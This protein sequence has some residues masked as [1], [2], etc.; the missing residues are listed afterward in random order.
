MPFT[1][2]VGTHDKGEL[3]QQRQVTA[4][5]SGKGGLQ[6]QASRWGFPTSVRSAPSYA[7]VAAESV[8]CID[9]SFCD[10]VLYT[11][12]N[13]N[14]GKCPLTCTGRIAAN[15][16]LN[17]IPYRNRVRV[18]AEKVADENSVVLIPDNGD[19]HSRSNA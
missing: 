11:F 6:K 19:E 9:C 5:I 1:D 17:L 15:P 18:L 12:Q 13:D 14:A 10:V 8:G 16:K 2:E 4:V 3:E 7:G